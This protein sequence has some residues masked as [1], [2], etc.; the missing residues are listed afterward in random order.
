MTPRSVRSVGRNMI[1]NSEC[2]SAQTTPSKSVTKP[3]N[4]G[5]AS[6]HSIK[7]PMNFGS[8]AANFAALAKGVPMSSA[9]TLVVN[10][11]E[12]PHFELSGS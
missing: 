12:V 9:S 11:V 6:L 7:N 3:P 10:T 8:R 2:G 1:S 4:P 5:F